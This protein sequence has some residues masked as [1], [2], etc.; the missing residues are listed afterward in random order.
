MTRAAREIR[1]RRTA[2]AATTAALAMV[3]LTCAASFAPAAPL[4]GQAVTIRQPDGTT[5]DIHVW[6]D[7]YFAHGETHEGYTVTRDPASGFL[8]YAELSEDGRDLVS[9]GVPAGERAPGRLARHIRLPGDVAGEL[10][11]RSRD[12]FRERQLATFESPPRGGRP[13]TTTGE[14]VGITLLVDFSDD[15]ATIPASNFEDY[16]NQPGYSGYGNNGSIYDYFYDV[17]EGN[18]EYTNYVPTAYFRAPETKSYYCNPTI[19][20]GQRAQE[21]IAAALD[22]LEASGFDFSQYDAD[23]DGVVDAVNCFYAG[24]TWNAWAEGLWPHA[25]WLQWSADGVTTERYQI[26]NTG[27]SLSL[28]TFC[29]ENGHMLMGWPDLYDYDGD[30]AGVGAFCLMCGGCFGTNPAEPCAY[31]KLDAGWADVIDLWDP[32]VDLPLDV[33]GN[34]MYRFQRVGH[35]NEFFLIENR[36]KSGRD[37]GLPDHGLALWHVDTEGNNSNQQQLPDLHYLVTLVQADGRWDLENNNNSGDATDLYAA[38]SYTECSPTSSPNTEWWD[39]SPSQA[40]FTDISSSGPMMTFDFMLVAYGL[41][42]FAPSLAAEIEP[43]EAAIHSMTLHNYGTVPDVVSISVSQD[44]LPPGVSQSEW[45]VH[46][47][48]DGGPWKV[49]PSDVTMSAGETLPIDVRMTDTIGTTVGM[50]LSTLSAESHGDGAVLAS[51]SFATFVGLPSILL[52]DDDGGGS[53]ETLLQSA[54]ADTGYAARTWDTSLLGRPTAEALESHWAVLWTTADGDAAGMDSE[55]EQRLMD[56]LDAGGNL[57]LSSMNYLSS[58]VSSNAFIE[59]YLRVDS[60]TADSGCFVVGGVAGDPISD[61]MSLGLLSG[62]FPPSESDALVSIA[63]AVPVFQSSGI[64]RGLRVEGSGYRV[65]F[66]SFP[67]E[68]VKV[69]NAAPSNQRTLV[70]RI[71]EW[72]DGQTG[73]D[74]DP[75]VGRIGVAANYPNPFNP[76]TTISFTVPSAADRVTLSVFDASGRLVTTL[77]DSPL[78]AGRHEVAWD[79]TGRDGR[80]LASGIYFARLEADGVSATRKMTLL[81]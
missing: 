15:P 71:L 73:I 80:R 9:T 33:D 28:G 21:L 18:L 47:R 76:A 66:T 61:G 41:E 32:T 62:P 67:F 46:Y 31:F 70:A 81:K 39:R 17:S 27:S 69:E 58:R 34:M 56:Y 53:H 48:V 3:L 63:P 36:Q 72:F 12:G 22:A 30:S 40:S 5:V 29:H 65:V 60:W 20:Y 26:T 79:G 54:L 50:A 2:F 68:D 51:K 14:V 44:E 55:D 45:N 43:G 52:V 64:E 11:R 49:F 75:V 25:G 23:G 37:A 13:G 8:C 1:S 59:D 4:E 74:A 16:C 42:S 57:Y 6:G 78:E 7:E 77:V 19:P 10:A 38:P 35:P 24:N